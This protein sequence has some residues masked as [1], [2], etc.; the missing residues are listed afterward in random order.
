MAI[1]PRTCL[2]PLTVALCVS[3]A[4]SMGLTYR[5]NTHCYAA[6]CSERH[7]P[8]HTRIQVV[9]WYLWLALTI[10]VLGFRSFKP[11]LR[12]FLG[13]QLRVPGTQTRITLSTPLMAAWIISL[14]GTITGIWWRELTVYYHKRDQ[15][16]ET[17]DA[18]GCLVATSLTGQWCA[19]SL[20]LALAPVSRHSALGSFFK[21]TFRDTQHFHTCISHVLVVLSIV[22]LLIYVYW[23]GYWRS[24]S[25]QQQKV[26]P[27]YN[28][29]Y[30]SEDVWPESN[31]SLAKWRASLLF[32]GAAAAFTMIIIVATS[33]PLVRRRFFKVFSYIHTTSIVAV[34][35]SC[36]HSNSVLYCAAPGISMYILDKSMRIWELH[37]E[38]P[39][40]ITPLGKGWYL[41]VSPILSPSPMLT[42]QTQRPPPPLTPRRLRLLFPRGT[43]LYLPHRL[44]RPRTAPL[45]CHHS[46]GSRRRHNRA[47]RKF[48]HHRIPLPS[49]RWRNPL[50][51]RHR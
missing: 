36:L 25:L 14:Y 44:C 28:P 8:L 38:L 5:S 45:H 41:Y 29:V 50:H 48:H 4:L 40:R 12:K 1:T 26:F 2:W 31:A 16:G 32:T 7:S 39:G 49:P 51:L 21:L 22:H 20:G 9:V 37:S 30:L 23:A 27:V 19:L 24:L 18:A 47:H 33:F 34:I 46:P 6:V 43:F 13:R 15:E 3:F 10:A 11:V 17:T 42:P 35:L